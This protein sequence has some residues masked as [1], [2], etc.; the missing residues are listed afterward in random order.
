M[1]ATDQAAI[2]TRFVTAL[3]GS[4]L[5]LERGLTIAGQLHYRPVAAT[6]VLGRLLALGYR[7]TLADPPDATVLRL[8]HPEVDDRTG[9]R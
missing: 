6:E 9:D 3:A 5:V 4:G 1:N 8:V 2:A 7:I